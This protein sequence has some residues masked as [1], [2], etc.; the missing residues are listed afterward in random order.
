MKTGAHLP[1]HVPGTCAEDVRALA[2]AALGRWRTLELDA[3][4][5]ALPERLDD[6][7]EVEQ[8]A[9]AVLGFNGLLV[10]T[11]RRVLLFA[12]PPRDGGQ[13]WSVHRLWIRA[14]EAVDDELRLDCGVERVTL[15][16]VQPVEARAGLA[17]RLR[18]VVAERPSFG[19][20]PPVL[21][22]P[23]T[24][25]AA[26]AYLLPYLED[27]EAIVRPVLRLAL[28]ELLVRE[29]LRI[30]SVWVRRRL[31]PGWR[32]TWLLTAGPRLGAPQPP[33]LAPLLA[34]FERRR[35]ERTTYR[36]SAA[37]VALDELD[38]EP[39]LLAACTESLV[40]HGLMRKPVMRTEDGDAAD[41]ALGEWLRLARVEPVDRAGR[42]DLTWVR[43]LLGGAGAAVLLADEA[44]GP[45]AGLAA[46]V[47]DEPW[48]DGR[49]VAAA[50][51]DEAVA[52]IDAAS[53]A[54]IV[55]G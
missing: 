19:A 55:D 10:L 23:W 38:P 15:Q 4:I 25:T 14:A 50:G 41:D 3:A 5:V 22:R 36:R 1:G 54:T 13:E 7:E 18:P 42:F 8:V 21:R 33:A 34:Q 6:G 28:I 49:L 45:L 27:G 29:A 16:Q 53:R 17:Q 2:R 48:L 47:P 37:G 9:S 24:L 11:D 52:V 26:E 39:E 40:S 20:G 31:L 12:R 32:A 46:R 35:T 43:A 51:L 44:H 30:E